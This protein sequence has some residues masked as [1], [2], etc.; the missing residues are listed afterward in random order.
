QLRQQRANVLVRPKDIGPGGGKGCFITTQPA[1]LA[2]ALEKLGRRDPARLILVFQGTFEEMRMDGVGWQVSVRRQP[3][4]RPAMV[5]KPDHISEIENQDFDLHFVFLTILRSSVGA[6]T[7]KERYT[8]APCR[9]RLR[10]NHELL[11][12]TCRLGWF[13]FCRLPAS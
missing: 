6:A 9:S 11:L 13:A 12:L 10:R 5:K 7:D 1:A 4:A 8:H 3:P 2:G